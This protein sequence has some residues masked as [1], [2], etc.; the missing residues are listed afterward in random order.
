M[1]SDTKRAGKEDWFEITTNRDLFAGEMTHTGQRQ[2]EWQWMIG[3]ILNLVVKTASTTL[4]TGIVADTKIIV[5]T[6]RQDSVFSSYTC[7]EIRCLFV[8]Y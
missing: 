4:T 6:G 8:A 5:W 2:S 7:M 1:S 3:I